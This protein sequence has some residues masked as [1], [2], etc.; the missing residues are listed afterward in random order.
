M[1]S[2]FAIIPLGKR[3]LVGLLILCSECRVA[4]VVLCL[5]LEVPWVGLWRVIVAFPSQTRVESSLSHWV[6]V[7]GGGGGGEC[8]LLV[9]NLRPRFRCC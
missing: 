4:V 1:L 5:F 7:C 3:E 8:I 6:C 9:P 2:V